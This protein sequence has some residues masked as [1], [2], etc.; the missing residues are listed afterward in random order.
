MPE[1]VRVLSTVLG[2]T[3]IDKSGFT[4]L[5]DV[6]LDFVPDET[7]PHRPLPRQALH[8]CTS[9]A[10]PFSRPCSNSWACGCESAKGPVEVI[11]V[12]HV[13]RPSAN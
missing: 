11:I 12:D 2:R 7:A 9:A 4:G 1:F 5:F 3:V 10:R 8:L 6:H 13:E